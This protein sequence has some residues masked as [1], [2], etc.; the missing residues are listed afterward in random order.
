MD[1]LS[2]LPC[3]LF[4]SATCVILPAMITLLTDFGTS[5]YF[6]GALKG[7]I[8]SINPN[9]RLVD[10]THEIAAHDIVAGAFTLNACYADFPVGT[11][12]LAVVDPG[13]G[14]SRRPIVAVNDGHLFV[15][16]DNGIFGLIFDRNNSLQVFHAT[17][18]R[19]FREHTIST[20]HGRD[21]F[22]PLAAHI[23]SGLDPREVGP[24]ISDYQRLV[25]S[26]V[27][28]NADT[29]SVTGE[30][31]HIDHFGNCIT[32]ISI[33]A[34]D[35]HRPASLIVGG[36]RITKFVEYFAEASEGELFVYAGSAGYLEIG[37]WCDSAAFRFGIKRGDVV[38][39]ER[40][41]SRSIG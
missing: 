24:E 15:G 36:E 31:L 3:L 39:L 33:T 30:V 4:F 18:S 10:M 13:V 28:V 12:H 35:S 16:P 32:N 19:L 37:L 7:T 21:I 11:V 9:A 22:A 26:P 17:D 20:F 41:S 34:L 40:E 14:S 2:P 8:L 38:V 25:S 29:G 23:D 5:D 1:Q 6:V 27:R